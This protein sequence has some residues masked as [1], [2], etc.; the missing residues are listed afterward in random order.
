MKIFL[1]SQKY[2][3]I[4]PTKCPLN[5]HCLIRDILTCQKEVKTQFKFLIKNEF[6][7]KFIKN[8]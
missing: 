6:G 7:D 4:S 8:K 5:C 1:H 2:E 3:N